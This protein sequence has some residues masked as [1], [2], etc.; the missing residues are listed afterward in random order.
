MQTRTKI[1]QPLNLNISLPPQ[2]PLDL[3]L[4]FYKTSLENSL[5]K[6][7]SDPI[8]TAQQRLD[9]ARRDKMRILAPGLDDTIML[10]TSANIIQKVSPEKQSKLNFSEFEPNNLLKTAQA[11]SIDHDLS[12]LM[13]PIAIKSSPIQSDQSSSPN[14]TFNSPQRIITPQYTNPN[15]IDSNKPIYLSQNLN[16]PQFPLQRSTSVTD[17]RL[18]GR[19]NSSPPPVAPKNVYRD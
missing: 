3:N 2:F 18:H 5:L 11:T 10:P 4:Y 6:D 8:S 15:I 16:Q 14:E 9:S 1:K 13:Q 17:T 12:Q 19:N 7:Q